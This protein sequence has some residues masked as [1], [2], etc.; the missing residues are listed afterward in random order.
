MSETSK[1]TP[2]KNNSPPGPSMEPDWNNFPMDMNVDFENDALMDFPMPETAF[3]YQPEM[4]TGDF[5]SQ[6]VIS[7]GLEEPLPPEEM[8]RDL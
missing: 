4:P 1:N 8:I 6:E 7:L 5:F 2:P 3:T